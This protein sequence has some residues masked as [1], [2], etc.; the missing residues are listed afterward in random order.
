M[1]TQWLAGRMR[2]FPGA[3]APRD[4]REEMAL[5]QEVLVDHAHQLSRRHEKPGNPPRLFVGTPGTGKTTCLCKWL[6][7][8]VFLAN[9]PAQVWRLDGVAPN[10]AEFLSVHGEILSV[11]VERVWAGGPADD[12]TVRFVD[13]PGVSASDPAAQA[14]LK[15]QVGQFHGAECFLVLNA[16]YDLSLLLAHTRAFVGLPL[17]GLIFT[18]MDEEIHVGKIWNVMLGSQLP[19]AWIS[20]GQNIP[21]QFT[22][23]LPEALFDA[24]VNQSLKG[25]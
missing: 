24:L 13:L 10:T 23:A 8:E 22:R 3:T 11:P 17:S 14:A 9:R 19:V 7:Q 2:T 6:T 20:G 1:H 4:L 21:G 25:E 18:H 5:A 16:A 15:A 12:A